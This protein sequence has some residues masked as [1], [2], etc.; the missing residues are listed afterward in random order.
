MSGIE[1]KRTKCTG[2]GAQ[3]TSSSPLLMERRGGKEMREREK[4]KGEERKKNTKKKRPREINI[5]K[6]EIWTGK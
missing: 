1:K 5:N 2:R 4:K 6:H 3:V